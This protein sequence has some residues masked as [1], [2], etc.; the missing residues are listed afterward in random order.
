[1]CFA[2]KLIV[3]ANKFSLDFEHS[4]REK[5]LWLQHLSPLQHLDTAVVPTM[6]QNVS[7]DASLI[8]TPQ[9][10]PLLSLGL[11][12]VQTFLNVELNIAFSSLFFQSL[13]W[14]CVQ[15]GIGSGSNRGNTSEIAANLQLVSV[16]QPRENLRKLAL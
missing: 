9:N 10:H 11:V 14:T 12:H 5:G 8:N 15:F 13:N 3:A 16:A 1:V 6:H 2:S 7:S 4:Y